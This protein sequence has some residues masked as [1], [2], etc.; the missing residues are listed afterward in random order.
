MRESVDAQGQLS[1]VTIPE[2]SCGTV[3]GMTN[4]ARSLASGTARR[5]L[6]T[7]WLGLILVLVA[8]SLTLFV[9]IFRSS[10]GL[11]AYGIGVAS[12]TLGASFAV[13]GWLVATRTSGNPLGWVYLGVGLSQVSLAFVD[14]AAY[15]GLVSAPGSIPYADMLSWV[16]TWIWAPGFTL[17]ISFSLLLFPTGRLPSPRWRPVAWLAVAS[18]LLA[19]GANAIGSWPLRGVALI[20]GTPDFPGILGLAAMIG[21]LMIPVVAIASVASIVIRFGRSTG[22][23]RLQ[24]KWFT[25]AAIVEIAFV[26]AAGLNLFD[27]V[28]VTLFVGLLV[29]PL[30]PIAIGIAILRYHL[31]EIDAVV[32]RAIAYAIVALILG[33]VYLG[34]VLTLESVLVQFTNGA[35]ISVV[36]STLAV[37]ALSQPLVRRVRRAVDRRFDRVRYDAEQTAASFSERLR[38]EVDLDAVIADLMLTTAV[39]LAPSSAAVWIRLIR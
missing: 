38:D 6:A 22:A 5:R 9:G 3:P 10:G 33:T 17:L 12:L 35:T 34:A 1:S 7:V 36:A 11:G 15:F 39:S 18:M 14:N 4:K 21:G 19:G 37:Y 27:P 2:R 16:G 26:V 23:E 8:L 31:Y 20:G 25:F 28:F 29:T 32:S 30:L 13:V 24:L